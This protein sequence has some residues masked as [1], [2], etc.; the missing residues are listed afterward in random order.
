VKKSWIAAA[1]ALVF[2]GVGLLGW[3]WSSA[4]EARWR[5]GDAARH[6][7]WLEA[8]A[9]GERDS[10]AITTEHHEREMRRALDEMIAYRRSSY[11]GLGGAVPVL[12]AAALI[13]VMGRRR[14]ATAL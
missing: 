1:V 6:L 4:S 14:A 2:V 12:A 9:K 11:Y 3:A 7:F 13:L 5:D 10:Y 8:A